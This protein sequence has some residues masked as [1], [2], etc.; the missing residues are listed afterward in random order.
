M[1]SEDRSAIATSKV[2]GTILM[3]ALTILLAVLVL[4]MI[5]LPPLS[6]DGGPP[7]IFQIRDVHHRSDRS[8]HPLNYDSRIVLIHNGT[9]SYENGR[10]K[11]EFYLNNRLLNA[12]ASTLNGHQFISTRH[13]GIQWIGG[14][15]CSGTT[16][17]PGEQL[18]IDF[19]D[20]TFHQGDHVQVDIIDAI[21]NMVISRH[22]HTA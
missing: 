3:V 1:L 15:G 7:A 16:W 17:E 6:F 4:L 14:S 13:N 11:A 10:L 18:V 9:K 8:P 2:I 21:T 22:C 5:H 20:G 12:R 19:T